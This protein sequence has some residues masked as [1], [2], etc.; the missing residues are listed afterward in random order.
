MNNVTNQVIVELILAFCAKLIQ[1]VNVQQI[2][3]GLI[4]LV[5]VNKYNL[6]IYPTN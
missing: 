3:I 4:Y 2:H 1:D 5:V 6:F